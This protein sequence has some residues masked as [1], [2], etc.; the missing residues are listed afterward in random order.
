MEETQGYDNT[1]SSPFFSLSS[2]LF[3]VHDKKIIY[4]CERERSK[5]CLHKH[6]KKKITKE[7]K[8]NSLKTRRWKIIMQILYLDLEV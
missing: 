6:N 3:F 4:N 7:R 8:K 2:I 1:P 5:Y